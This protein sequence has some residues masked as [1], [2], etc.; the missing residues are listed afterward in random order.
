MKWQPLDARQALYQKGDR[1]TGLAVNIARENGK[2]YD[3]AVITFDDLIKYIPMEAF[4][5]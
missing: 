4:Y 2:Y 3:Y 5:K 1:W